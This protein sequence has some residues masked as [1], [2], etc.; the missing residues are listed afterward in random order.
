MGVESEDACVICLDSEGEP[1]QGGCACRGSAGLAHVECRLRLA[2]AKTSLVR[3][4]TD[5]WMCS[6]CKANFTGE[7]KRYLSSQLTLRAARD[8]ALRDIAMHIQISTELADGR[9]VAAEQNALTHLAR[10]RAAYG[11]EGTLTLEVA[12]FLAEA[13]AGQRRDEEAADIRSAVL[14]ASRRA[15]G[16]ESGRTL[17]AAGRLAISLTRTGRYAAAEALLR[18]SILTTTRVFGPADLHTL[19]QQHALAQNLR[20]QGAHDEAERLLRGV[21]AG[22]RRVL[23]PEHPSTVN[24]VREI[25]QLGQKD[26]RGP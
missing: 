10:S 7:T 19:G 22:T 21:L 1:T 2:E 25:A 16:E 11:D 24:L 5:W 14:D 13:L 26:A 23:G 8:V 12:A 6:T 9:F 3:V 20:L 15:L 4:A 18:Q 17:N